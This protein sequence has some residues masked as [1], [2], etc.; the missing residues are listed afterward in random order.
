MP[1][2]GT[3]PVTPP[4]ETPGTPPD[5][6]PAGPAPI[7]NLVAENGFRL[8]D[9]TWTEPADSEF[10]GM[11]ITW[12]P[13]DGTP[14]TPQTVLKGAAQPVTISG[15]TNGTAYTFTVKAKDTAGNIVAGTSVTATP[16]YVL[17]DPENPDITIKFGRRRSPSVPLTISE[18]FASLHELISNPQGTDDFTKI[19]ELG[20]Y[21]NLVSLTING[22]KIDDQELAYGGGRS[23]GLMVVGKNSFKRDGAANNNL[24]APDHVVFHFR[25]V[26]VRY[27]MSYNLY[28]TNGYDGSPMAA[29]IRNYFL[30]GL[31]AAAG[32]TD[33]MLWA[34]RR[35][36]SKGG[37]P[38]AGVDTVEDTLW[39]PTEWEMFG[40]RF[41]SAEIEVDAGQAWLEYYT[42]DERRTKFSVFSP[43]QNPGGSFSPGADT[44]WLASASGTNTSGMGYRSVYYSGEKNS[45]AATN[46][47][48]CVPAFCIK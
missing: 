16:S 38:I 32:L 2:A 46:N 42:T 30:P 15:L 26:P 44:Y 22:A 11:E 9:L 19:I 41:G 37:Y 14:V 5:G 3:I 7:T 45:G 12:T 13:D 35:M 47:D 20:D 28:N 17:V 36:V 25:N 34:P 33:E 6:G 31:K 8:V 40:E 18:T 29:Y 10:A 23:L 48:G 27:Q 24:G 4:P 39:L 21:I 43:W 1:G